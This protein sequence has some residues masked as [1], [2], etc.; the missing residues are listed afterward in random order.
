[1]PQLGLK[2]LPPFLAIKRCQ[3]TK[4]RKVINLEQSSSKKLAH[5]V[6]ERPK[7]CVLAMSHHHKM[8]IW[9]GISYIDFD[10]KLRH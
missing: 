5:I 1:M 8:M 7:K 6:W 3:W 9:G 4:I 2:S 10:T